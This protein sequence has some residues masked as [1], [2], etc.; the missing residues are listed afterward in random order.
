VN[1]NYGDWLEINAH[2]DKNVMSTA[3]Y[4]R[5]A[6]LMSK[7]ALAIGKTEDA[8]M[9]SDLFQHIFDAFNKNYVKS[10][11]TIEGDTQSV[12]S[13]VQKSI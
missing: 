5:D 7:M 11:A 8:K 9:Y 10:D 13:N 3:Y 4:A 2:T 1:N 6:M 12:I